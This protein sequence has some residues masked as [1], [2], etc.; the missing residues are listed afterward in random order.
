MD[1]LHLHV[2][3][4]VIYEVPHPTP[5]LFVVQAQDSG[6]QRVLRESRVID[7]LVPV[8]QVLDSYGNT[9]W[10]M[11]APA[12]TLR[13]RYDALVS[14]PAPPDLV[15]PHLRK[16]PIEALPGEALS[17][18]WPTRYCPSDRL[19]DDAW[20][21]FGDVPGGW[22]Q[23]QAVCDWMHTNIMYGSGSTSAT[24]S[25]EV[26]AAR[27]GVC[28]DF[29]HLAVTFCRALNIPARYICGYLPDVGVEPDPTPMDFHAWFQVYLDGGWRTFD[30]RHNRPRSGR[31]IIA[32]GR[33]AVDGAWSTVFGSARLA[34]FQVWADEVDAAFT[35]DDSVAAQAKA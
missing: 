30:A 10:R 8:D 4:G 32:T 29:A 31:T 12:G 6:D 17:Y 11:V 19:I 22:A 25:L 2:G 28:R 3:C 20:R 24:D 26:Y 9:V 33:D 16:T 14:V 23:V 27:R 13:V 34:Q 18:L 7:P 35:L 5:I 15:L 21:L 1:R